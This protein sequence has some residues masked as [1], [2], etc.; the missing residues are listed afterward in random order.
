MTEDTRNVRDAFASLD[1]SRPRVDTGADDG[2]LL[3]WPRAVRLI[4]ELREQ[5]EILR[6]SLDLYAHERP[7][8]SGAFL[9]F[10]AGAVSAAFTLGIIVAL[11]LFLRRSL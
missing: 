1:T 5:N 11:A 8:P 10:A 6:G 3:D 9:A 7:S 2:E 4:R